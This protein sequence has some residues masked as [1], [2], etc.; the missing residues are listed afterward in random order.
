MCLTST[1]RRCFRLLTRFLEFS[2][3]EIRREPLSSRSASKLAMRRLG[4]LISLLARALFFYTCMALIFWIGTSIGFTLKDS[5]GDLAQTAPVMVTSGTCKFLCPFFLEEF[6]LNLLGSCSHCL[7]D[8]LRWFLKGMWCR[9]F[10][11]TRNHRCGFKYL[12]NDFLRILP[13]SIP[14]QD[15]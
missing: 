1:F 10:L 14:V 4:W 13:R 2:L 15:L 5:L 8:S 7:F 3:E 6:P 11:M 9:R 12:L